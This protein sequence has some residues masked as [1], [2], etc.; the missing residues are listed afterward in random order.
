MPGVKVDERRLA[1]LSRKQISMK[2]RTSLA[3]AI[4]CS[5]VFAST[6]AQAV[7]KAAETADGTVVHGQATAPKAKAATAKPVKKKSARKS[8]GKA[9]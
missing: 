2:K 6:G 9:R 8:S 5:A 4:V 3:V 7:P 1:S